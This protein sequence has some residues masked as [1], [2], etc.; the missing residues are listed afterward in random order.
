MTE[1]I[2]HAFPM[3]K[4]SLSSVSVGKDNGRIAMYAVANDRTNFVGMVWL[5]VVGIIWVA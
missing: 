3:W 2:C 1:S 5:R 4:E